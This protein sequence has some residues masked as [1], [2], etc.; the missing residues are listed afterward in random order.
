MS[1]SA[2]IMNINEPCGP[3][4]LKTRKRLTKVK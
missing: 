4:W 3:D 2:E 1:L